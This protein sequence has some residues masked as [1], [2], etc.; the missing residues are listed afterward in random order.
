MTPTILHKQLSATEALEYLAYAIYSKDL[1]EDFNGKITCEL[2]A[3]GSVEVYA[4]FNEDT[5]TVLP[6]KGLGYSLN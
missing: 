1:P 6:P 4:T 2:N 5:D 3:D